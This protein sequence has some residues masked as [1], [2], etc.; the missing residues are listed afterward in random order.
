M[1]KYSNLPMKAFY[2]IDTP[3]RKFTFNDVSRINS[4]NPDLGFIQSFYVGENATEDEFSEKF[5]GVEC[6]WQ[7]EK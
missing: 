1:H 3:Y 6:I 5:K 7:V 4:L 2:V